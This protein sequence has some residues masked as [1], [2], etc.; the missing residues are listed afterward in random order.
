MK[1]YTQEARELLSNSELYEIKA[2]ENF[3]DDDLT[4]SECDLCAQCVACSSSCVA[5]SS[6]MADVLAA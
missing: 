5:C 2:G 6:K 1:N 3:Q 4:T